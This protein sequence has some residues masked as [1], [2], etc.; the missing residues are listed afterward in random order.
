[1]KRPPITLEG[2]PLHA[3]TP[4]EVIEIA[5]RR[6]RVR[7][8]LGR[9][10][11]FERNVDILRVFAGATER[12]SSE[13]IA[14]AA[15]RIPEWSEQFHA[16]RAGET[17]GWAVELGIIERISLS[18][19]WR[20]L[21]SERVFECIGNYKTMR[22]LRVRGH[23][24]GAEAIAAARA[25]KR[26]LGR[27]ERARIK[28]IESHRPYIVRALDRIVAGAPEMKLEGYLA[29]FAV[30]GFDDVGSC[31]QYIIDSL[32]SLETGDAVKVERELLTLVIRVP[33]APKPIP[34]EDLAALGEIQL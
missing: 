31:R 15:A 14:A 9:C 24:D 4:L 3:F 32:P 30:A 27:R 6:G 5:C 12:T 21:E 11:D 22:S 33:S 13:F 26:E 29:R 28:E 34:A 17:L 18:H 19:K 20:L 2:K 25:W 8:D 23:A 7:Y 16:L 10:G 1:M